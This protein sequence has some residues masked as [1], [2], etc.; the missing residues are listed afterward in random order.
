M[1]ILCEID[2]LQSSCELIRPSLLWRL[3]AGISIRIIVLQ[4]DAFI[5]SIYNDRHEAHW[6]ILNKDAISKIKELCFEIVL[7]VWKP[8]IC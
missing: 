4:L 1:R 3:T 6:K 2:F 8:Y 7:D 5:C